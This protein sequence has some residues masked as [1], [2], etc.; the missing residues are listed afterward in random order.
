VCQRKPEFKDYK[1]EQLLDLDPEE[2]LENS[3][4][5]SGDL[6]WEPLGSQKVDLKVQPKMLHEKIILAKLREN[7]EIELELY[8]SKNVGRVHAKWSPVATAYYR[9]QPLIELKE[10]I[11][12]AD[13]KTI[14]PL[15]IFPYEFSLID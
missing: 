12:G 2:Y 1:M 8:C 15:R 9:L 7:Q 10:E 14:F 13:V 3:T 5:Y 4:I 6:E 11:S